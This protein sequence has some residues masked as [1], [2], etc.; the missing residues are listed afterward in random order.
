[1][2]NREGIR[3]GE[4]IHMGSKCNCPQCGYLTEGKKV[5]NVGVENDTKSFLKGSAKIA[6]K[7]GQALDVIPGGRIV[8]GILSALAGSAIDSIPDSEGSCIKFVCPRCGHKW[9]W[10]T[11]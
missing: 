3:G 10:S 11:R 8:G 4:E 7:A 2:P 9:K 1:M 6:V 5:N